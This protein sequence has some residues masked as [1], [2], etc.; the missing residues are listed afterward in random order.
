MA[1][2]KEKPLTRE[3][4]LRL[5]KE[6]GGKAEG[7]DLSR[8]VFEK[9]ID[10]RR[11][12]LEGIILKEAILWDIT[13]EE[14]S[15]GHVPEELHQVRKPRHAGHQGGGAGSAHRGGVTKKRGSRNL[16]N[17]KGRPQWPLFSFQA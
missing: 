10:L 9:G 14:P 11:L 13:L 3:D 7:L 4:V 16:K 8:K 15:G 12:N 2:E 5:I 1:G 6:N 17:K